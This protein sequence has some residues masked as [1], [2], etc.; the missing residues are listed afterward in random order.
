M[1]IRL[2]SQWEAE[3]SPKSANALTSGAAQGGRTWN[4]VSP[5]FLLAAVLLLAALLRFGVSSFR[6]VGPDEG[7][8]LLD[9]RLILQGKV[10]II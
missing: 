7:S 4:A 3:T 1:K 2:E 10:P 8:Y 5:T 6:W 9:A